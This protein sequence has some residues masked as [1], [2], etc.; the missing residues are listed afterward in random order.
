M[1]RDEQ[2]REAARTLREDGINGELISRMNDS[3]LLQAV[4]YDDYNDYN[5]FMDWMAQKYDI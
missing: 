5:D 1:T 2:L 4:S 3:E